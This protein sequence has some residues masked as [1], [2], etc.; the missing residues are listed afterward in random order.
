MF[1]SLY[2]EQPGSTIG[3]I[4]MIQARRQGKGNDLIDRIAEKYIKQEEA[5]KKGKGQRA[6]NN[7]PDMLSGKDFSNDPLSDAEFKKLQQKLFNKK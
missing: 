2:L 5:D 4:A 1:L 3:L 7:N 6:A